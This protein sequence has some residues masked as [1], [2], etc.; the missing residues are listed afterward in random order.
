[1]T[2][3]IYEKTTK[4]SQYQICEGDAASRRAAAASLYNATALRRPATALL[5]DA[6]PS[7]HT[8]ATPLLPSGVPDVEL[9]MPGSYNLGTAEQP[10][11]VQLPG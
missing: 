7:R 6:A 5:L 2:N 3:L 1:M 8:T 4:I 11:K 10:F 9:S